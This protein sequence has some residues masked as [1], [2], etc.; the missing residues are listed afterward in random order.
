M[1]PVHEIVVL[2]IWDK[3]EKT[4]LR[5]SDKVIPKSAF[6]ATETS[7]NSEILLVASFTMIL[8]N[9]RITKV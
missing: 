8:S 4:C 9:K 7:Q 5:V 3:L 2:T 6:S 1:K